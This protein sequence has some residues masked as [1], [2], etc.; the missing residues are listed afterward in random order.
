MRVCPAPGYLSAV[1]G[2]VVANNN[3]LVL[4]V[5]GCLVLTG[6]FGFTCIGLGTVGFL[7]SRT[8]SAPIAAA[9]DADPVAREERP[10][11]TRV[12]LLSDAAF[13]DVGAGPFAAPVAVPVEV[14]PAPSEPVR[15]V[16]RPTQ[17]PPRA[18]VATAPSEPEPPPAEDDQAPI[19]SDEE[20]QA[21]DAEVQQIEAEKEAEAATDTKKKKKK[22]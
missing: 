4:G 18:P 22:N 21:L 15:P 5:L 1:A 10:A 7:Y 17:T 20:V 14:E 3:R 16:I 8:P 2:A 9:P 19:I 11:T 13:L 12:D 6:L